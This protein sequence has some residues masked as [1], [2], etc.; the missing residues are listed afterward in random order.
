MNIGTKSRALRSSKWGALAK[1]FVKGKSC[2][3]C[4]RKECLVVHHIQPFHLHPELEL[5]ESN[6]IVLCEGKIV[7][8]HLAVGHLFYW[9]SHN[10]DIVADAAYMNAKVKGRP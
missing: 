8:C 6:L 3:C 1:R 5:D 4:G 9:P 10:P 2:A 7:N